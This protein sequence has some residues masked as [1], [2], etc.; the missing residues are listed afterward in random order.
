MI[1]VVIPVRNSE[2]TVKESI[3][4]VINQKE[5][6]IEILCIINGTSDN[7]EKIIQDIKDKR[8]K[9]LHSEPGIVPALNTGLRHAKGEYIARQDADDVWLEDKL[10]KQLNFLK[11]N[12]NI[13][14]LGTQLNV[15]D[16]DNN[17]IRK[18]NYPINHNQIISNLLIGENSIGHPS[19]I[20]KKSVLDKCGGYY[21]LFPFAEDLDLWTRLIPWFKFAN[22]D[23]PLVR[24]K[25]IP[26]PNYNPSIP[27]IVS[28]WYRMIYNIK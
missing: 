26:N 5:E 12:T 13:D 15:V 8:I 14:I 9:I 27:K 24:Y 11:S 22:L 16:K 6:N 17:L 28:S 19:V 2:K 21:D 1:S 23:E 7:S 4:S 10:T 18:T 3:E 25:H 20:F